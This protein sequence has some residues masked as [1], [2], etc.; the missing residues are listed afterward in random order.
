MQ[1]VICSRGRQNTDFLQKN[2]IFRKNYKKKINKM[3][4]LYNEVS[5]TSSMAYE[6]CGQCLWVTVEA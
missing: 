3:K 1:K 6:S 5:N 4:Q 2:A